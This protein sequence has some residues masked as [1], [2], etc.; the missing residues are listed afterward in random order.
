MMSTVITGG[1]NE[2]FLE[3]GGGKVK[4]RRNSPDRMEGA[5]FYG[6]FYFSLDERMG[7]YAL[8]CLRQEPS[9]TLKDLMRILKRKFGREPEGWTDEDLQRIR[10]QA[11]RETEGM[12]GG[13]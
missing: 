7:S 3:Q 10:E 4:K 5:Q 9:L 1:R 12:L 13:F 8:G 6:K 2:K 11:L